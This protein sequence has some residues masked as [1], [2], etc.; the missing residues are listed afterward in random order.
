MGRGRRTE[1]MNLENREGDA[2]GRMA[3]TVAEATLSEASN[4]GW[5][6]PSR[7]TRIGG[8]PGTR[9]LP[10]RDPHWRPGSVSTGRCVPTARDPWPA[11]PFQVIQRKKPQARSPRGSTVPQARAA[12]DPQ[13]AGWG[14]ASGPSPAVI[15]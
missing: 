5:Y 10:P 14:G 11:S 13:G 8:F 3:L 1:K 12:R 7:T 4:R 9:D 2:V 15:G 6:P